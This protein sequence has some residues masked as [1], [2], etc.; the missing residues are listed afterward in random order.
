MIELLCKNDCEGSVRRINAWFA[1]EMIDRPPVRFAEHNAEYSATRRLEGRSWP[2]LRAR[3]FDVDY[4]V[5]LFLETIRDRRFHGETFPVFWPNL[6]PNAYAAF[7]GC[8]IEFGEVTSWIRHC[9]DE[10]SDI[11]RLKFNRNNV[12]YRKIEELTDA[13]LKRCDGQYLVGY[14]DLHG[15]L[16]CV[17]DWRGPERLCMDILDTPEFVHRLLDLAAENFLPLFDHYDVI[18]KAHGQPSVTWMGIPVEGKL[19]I[20][21]CDFGSL[22][23]PETFEE[24]YLP[25]LQNELAHMTHNIFHLDGKGMLR[26]L[27]RLLET[28]EIHAIQWVHGVGEDAPIMQWIPIVEKIQN[29]GKGVLLDL[30][31]EEIEPFIQATRPEGLFLCIAADEEMQPDILRRI[32]K[33]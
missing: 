32:E 4:Q 28:P 11:G 6:G 33:W 1:G 25:W 27:D 15:S 21:S 3:W 20:S 17:A 23:S 12:F 19:H 14:T 13:A 7:H 10:P 9:I 16:D 18:L 5:E 29:A 30:R 8:E 2:N 26:H 24:F 31:V 22:I